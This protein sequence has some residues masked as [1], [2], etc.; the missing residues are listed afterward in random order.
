[1]ISLGVLASLLCVWL[2]PFRK[3]VGFFF[4]KCFTVRKTY[5]L[6]VTVA[7]SSF[8]PSPYS[9]RR[10]LAKEDFRRYWT[11]IRLQRNANI[12]VSW[13]SSMSNKLIYIAMVLLF[14]FYSNLSNYFEHYLC[15]TPFHFY[16][17]YFLI[18]C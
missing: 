10:I 15:I 17:L 9:G 5:I 6:C 16:F 8:P 4:W 18:Y 11:L 2:C 3:S 14:L 7:S 13:C 1:M 12:I